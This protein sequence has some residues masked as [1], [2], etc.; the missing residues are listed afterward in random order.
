MSL[1]SFFKDHLR[2]KMRAQ[3]LILLLLAGCLHPPED[4]EPLIQTTVQDKYL[5]SLPSALSPFSSNELQEA[6]VNEV[7]IGKQF[8]QELDLYQTM[9]A[10]KR[11]SFLLPQEQIQKRLELDYMVCLSYYLGGKYPSVLHQFETSS[12]KMSTPVFNPYLD[13]LVMLYDAS[14]TLHLEDKK[15]ALMTYLQASYPEAANKLILIEALRTAQFNTLETLQETHP[16]IQKVLTMYHAHEKSSF[17]A[18]LFNALIPGS[19]YLYLGQ[20]QSAV[21]AFLLNTLFIWGSVYSFH[22]HHLALGVILAGFEA[23]W[24]FGGIHGVKDEVKLYNERLY[25]TLTIPMMNQHKYFP[26]FMLTYGF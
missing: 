17:K 22:H 21:T 13:L 5:K 3:L 15:E 12:L 2:P 16:E 7:K 25:E 11:A 18:Q 10:F 9:T 19:G 26:I 6:W 24:Y 14:A 4:I 8:A 20:K 23:G 1:S